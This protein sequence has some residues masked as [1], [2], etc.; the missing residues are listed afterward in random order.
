MIRKTA[1]S[2]TRR[3]VLAAA[4]AFGGIMAVA[5]P[6]EAAKEKPIKVAAIYTVPVEQQWRN[7]RQT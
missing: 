4:L 2:L 3:L 5:G 7:H 6:T 1:N